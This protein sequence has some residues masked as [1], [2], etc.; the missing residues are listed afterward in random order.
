MFDILASKSM[1][2]LS[3]LLQQFYIYTLVYAQGFTFHRN[4]STLRKSI[5]RG[6]LW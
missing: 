2:F 1:R 5:N 3:P 6:N 4:A